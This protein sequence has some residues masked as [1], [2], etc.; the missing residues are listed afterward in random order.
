MQKEDI[1]AKGT[2]N[3]E[4]EVFNLPLKGLGMWKD[5]PDPRFWT[6]NLLLPMEKQDTVGTK[7][8]FEEQK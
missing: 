1:I 3:I 8:K 4:K 7:I 5:T 6:G 2:Q